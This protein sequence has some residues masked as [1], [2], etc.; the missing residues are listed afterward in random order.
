LVI[1]LVEIG[2]HCR[3]AI[4]L[5]GIHLAT[6][7]LLAA[8]D[9]A[10]RGYEGFFFGRYDLRVPSEEH[11]KAGRAASVDGLGAEH[12]VEIPFRVH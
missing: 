12:R 8:I 5:D 9:A 4:F 1:E 7:E 3:G 6:P 2:N 11:L 10:S